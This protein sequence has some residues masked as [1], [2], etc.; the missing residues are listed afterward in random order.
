MPQSRQLAAI[1]FT[2]IEGYSALMQQNEQKAIMTKDRHRSVLENEHKKF[3]GN[4]IQYYGDGTLSIFTSAVQAVECALAMQQFFCQA[5]QIPVRIGLHTGDIIIN[6]GH[7]FGDGVNLAARIES[8]GV[9]GSV[10]ISD[11][12]NDEL[13]NHPEFKTLS[14]GI[15]NLKN[16]ERLVEVFALD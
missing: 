3:N 12:V 13:H 14:M 2:D 7:V 8:L 4:I 16:I 1:M 9:S 10:L 11:K 15:Y 6:D 5:P